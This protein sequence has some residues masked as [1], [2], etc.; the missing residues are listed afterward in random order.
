MVGGWVGRGW[1]FLVR[2][3]KYQQSH[4]MFSKM[5]VP[6]QVEGGL[7]RRTST[8][9]FSFC[10]HLVKT[11]NFQ[12]SDFLTNNKNTQTVFSFCLALFLTNLWLQ[13]HEEWFQELLGISASPRTY[14]NE[15]FPIF[16]E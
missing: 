7:I 11:T 9:F 5:L 16:E 8:V 3:R 10:T 4:F 2:N 15:D 1:G 14:K 6:F 13:N 12:G